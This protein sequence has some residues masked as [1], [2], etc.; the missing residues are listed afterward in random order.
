LTDNLFVILI[1]RK[2]GQFSF[3]TKHWTISILCLQTCL[4]NCLV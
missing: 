1:G 3:K 2:T 4:Q